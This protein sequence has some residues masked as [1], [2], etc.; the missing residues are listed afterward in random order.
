L[1][2][3]LGLGCSGGGS[4]EG[5]DGGAQSLPSDPHECGI[6]AKVSGGLEHDFGGTL[7]CAGATTGTT[8]FDFQGQKGNFEEGYAALQFSFF[9][10]DEGQTGPV[11][12][13]GVTLAQRPPGPQ[14]DITAPA[15]VLTWE[16]RAGGCSLNVNSTS[17]DPVV[18]ADLLWVNGEG[19]CSEAA[20][21]T[22]TNTAGPATIGPFAFNS[23]VLLGFR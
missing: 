20:I 4:G 2:A 22:G 12:V 1:V 17:L 11:T 14:S 8:I 3:S 21:A 16:V 5:S 9:A 18:P 13:E 6:V 19:T 23:Y 15:Q 10:P 7:D